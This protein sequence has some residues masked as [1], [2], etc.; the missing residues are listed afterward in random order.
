MVLMYHPQLDPESDSRSHLFIRGFMSETRV[1]LFNS[2]ATKPLQLTLP[3][4]RDPVFLQRWTAKDRQQ[5]QSLVKAA[6]PGVLPNLYEQLFIRSV[7]EEAGNLLCTVDDISE[8]GKLDGYM[9]ELIATEVIRMNGIGG[10]DEKKAP[11]PTTPN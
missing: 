1:R 4:G 3:G 10:D 5:F 8:V 2:M 7:C 11:S 6:S 9:L